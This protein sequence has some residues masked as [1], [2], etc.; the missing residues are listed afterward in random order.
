MSCQRELL[1]IWWSVP[2][3]GIQDQAV[4]AQRLCTFMCH[5]DSACSTHPLA[6]P[7]LCLAA[8]P[9]ALT[10]LVRLDASRRYGHKAP[11][12]SPVVVP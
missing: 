3:E 6:D 7:H 4:H 2:D 11:S 12:R 10:H 8:G 9:T 5:H 1:L